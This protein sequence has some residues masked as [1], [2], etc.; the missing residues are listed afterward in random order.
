[1]KELLEMH[2]PVWKA[3]IDN[4]GKILAVFDQAQQVR[5][6]HAKFDENKLEMLYI[7]TLSR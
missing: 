5:N 1:M 7:Y 4:Y 6:R 2:P 3:N